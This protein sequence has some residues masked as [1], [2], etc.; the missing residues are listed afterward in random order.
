MGSMVIA[1]WI[2]VFGQLAFV[3][4][5]G[6]PHTWTGFSSAAFADLGAIVKLSISS[7]VMLW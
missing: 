1:M 2:P 6:C 5:G 4:F 7:G 3:F